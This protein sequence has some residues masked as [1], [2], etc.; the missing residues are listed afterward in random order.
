MAVTDAALVG[1]GEEAAAVGRGAAHNELALHPLLSWLVRHFAIIVQPLRA[2]QL[3]PDV[4]SDSHRREEVVVVVE[5][6]RRLQLRVL[7]LVLCELGLLR[8]VHNLLLRLLVNQSLVR[9]VVRADSLPNFPHAIVLPLVNLVNLVV[10]RLEPHDVLVG[11]H[12][13]LHGGKN[14]LLPLK[15]NLP[16]MLSQSVFAEG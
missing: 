12:V 6:I 1:G 13:D 4:V 2:P 7:A 3:V 10:L 5:R 8:V 16:P 11:L 9:H 15:Q 14:G